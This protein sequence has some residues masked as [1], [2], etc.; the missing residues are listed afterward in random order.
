MPW[1]FDT[2]SPLVETY[3]I[4][5]KEEPDLFHQLLNQPPQTEEGPWPG[6]NKILEWEVNVVSLTLV[7]VWI[8]L[9]RLIMSGHSAFAD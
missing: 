5:R 2:A 9:S 4:L 8:A 6:A 3:K 7:Q 1:L